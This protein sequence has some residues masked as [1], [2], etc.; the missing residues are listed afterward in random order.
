LVDINVKDFGTDEV[1][2]HIANRYFLFT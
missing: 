2:M 1:L